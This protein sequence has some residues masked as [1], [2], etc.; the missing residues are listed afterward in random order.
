MKPDNILIGADGHVKLADFGLSAVGLMNKQAR[1]GDEEEETEETGEPLKAVEEEKVKEQSQPFV[2]DNAVKGT[3]HYLAPEILL[4]LPHGQAVDWW[5]LGVMLFE[6]CNGYP[7]FTGKDVENIFSEILSGHIQWP[8]EDQDE[9]SDA[10]K[11][12]ISRLLD[13]DPETRLQSAVRV[14]AHPFFADVDWLELPHEEPPFVP[15]S[16]S[17]TDTSA[18]EERDE[19]F[20]IEFDPTVGDDDDSD[21]DSV[22]DDRSDI[23]TQNFPAF[24]HISFQNLASKK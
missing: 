20:P 22:E 13:N 3:P 17:E 9:T 2:E 7:P 14:K 10:C 18:F 5:A 11:N 16:A 23:K 15:K 19:F 24:W 21:D 1:D 12:L 4:G 8:P 6:F